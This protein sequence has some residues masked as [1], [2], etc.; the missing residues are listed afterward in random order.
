MALC[1]CRVDFTQNCVFGG[2]LGWLGIGAVIPEDGL[3][4]D[5]Q[6]RF[7]LLLRTNRSAAADRTDF[8]HS[9]DQPEKP[10]NARNG[11]CITQDHV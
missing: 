2:L 9:N 10:E 7:V 8:P 6:E 3:K 5:E 11:R 1:L 4:V